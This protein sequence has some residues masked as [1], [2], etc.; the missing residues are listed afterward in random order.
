MRMWKRVALDEEAPYRQW[1]RDN[2]TPGHVINVL[3][4]PVVRHECESMNLEADRVRAEGTRSP[5]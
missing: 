1:A 5:V 2:F 3:W 4:H